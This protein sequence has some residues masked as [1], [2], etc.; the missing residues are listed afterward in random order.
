[1][2]DEQSV[3]I[4]STTTVVSSIARHDA[5][6]VT[7]SD[8]SEK[9][10]ISV[11]MDRE[12]QPDAESEVMLQHSK[13]G[14]SDSY[15][16]MPCDSE[17]VKPASSLIQHSAVFTDTRLQR[18]Y[19]P[20][21]AVDIRS[22][23]ADVDLQQ[24]S[25]KPASVDSELERK[26]LLISAVLE[27][28]TT[29]AD[30]ILQH[31]AEFT[32]DVLKVAAL[33]TDSGLRLQ[34]TAVNNLSHLKVECSDSVLVGEAGADDDN[35]VLESDTLSCDSS[36]E[37]DA[38]EECDDCTN[39]TV[40]ATAAVAQ[41]F[42]DKDTVDSSMSA[43]EPS[44]VGLLEGRTNS[45]NINISNVETGHELSARDELC[46]TDDSVNDST[47]TES[48]VTQRMLV[49]EPASRTA[50]AGCDDMNAANDCDGLDISCSGSHDLIEDIS[51]TD[52]GNRCTFS[53]LFTNCL[54]HKIK[55][56][57]CCKC[58]AQQLVL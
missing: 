1:M 20:H 35:E 12:Q 44:N 10:S 27:H 14:C 49:A 45:M 47:V 38:T 41:V 28:D 19:T 54:L 24:K 5:D 31:D 13:T 36:Q 3:V 30:T 29:P 55:H 8:L 50:A 18:E 34:A 39:T 4:A 42:S 58:L 37:L 16:A 53:A 22:V 52:K 23:R 9:A 51:T 2:S 7:E 6:V 46:V 43:G 40:A 17:H 15:E 48:L 32:S 25:Y 26:D 11:M 56:A 21:N 33:S 57:I